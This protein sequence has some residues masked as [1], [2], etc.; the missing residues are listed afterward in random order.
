MKNNE[1]SGFSQYAFLE[2]YIRKGDW[3]AVSG[4]INSHPEAMRARIT[5]NGSTALH[6]AIFAGRFTSS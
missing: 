5:I 1:N 4:F 2:K 3:D 6:V